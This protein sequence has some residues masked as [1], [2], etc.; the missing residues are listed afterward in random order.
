MEKELIYF[1]ILAV[2]SLVLIIGLT[3]SLNRF[4]T[5]FKSELTENEDRINTLLEFSYDIYYKNPPSEINIDN[6]YE[7]TPTDLRVCSTNDP[8]SCVGCKSL[9]SNCVHFD[10][11]SKYVDYYGVEYTIPK[12]KTDTEGYCLTRKNPSQSCNPYHG[13]LILLQTNPEAIESMLYCDCKNPGYIGSL[14]INGACDDAFVCDGKLQNINVPLN[15]I[16]CDCETNQIATT[17]NDTPVCMAPTI[18]EFDKYDD[19]FYVNIDTVP[20]DRFNSDIVSKFPG[21]K[22]KNP[23]K[24]CLLTGNYIENGIM[25]ESEDGWQCATKI[26]KNG[27]LPIR[28]DPKYRVLSG[29]KG[30][31]AILDMK[32]HELFV[33]GYIY[34]S[35]YEQM[36]LSLDTSKNKDILDRMNIDR[37]KKFVYINLRDHNLVFPGSFG[38][39]RIDNSATITCSGT[40]LPMWEDDFFYTCR[41]RN[42][43]SDARKPSGYMLF[44]YEVSSKPK[45]IAQMAPVCPPKQHS[46]LINWKFEKWK[47]YESK[48]PTFRKDVTNALPKY[49]MT[50]EFKVAWDAGYIMYSYHF[51]SEVATFYGTPD[52][53]LYETWIRNR[54]PK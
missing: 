54:I 7:C 14:T 37:S 26:G 36:M 42:S 35:T 47:H 32:L 49:E 40:E 8:L 43:V 31:D 51:D 2:V 17:I 12:N 48:N 28:R 16:K 33:H 6:P 24:Y 41:F 1:I 10:V 3:V 21:D 52:N 23:C 34:D 44:D 9:L 5:Q 19:L 39:M 18:G 27:G 11:D 38:S 20:S 15:E 4:N 29:S 46:F 45:V 13:E 30:P 22:I 25:V 50:E 53:P